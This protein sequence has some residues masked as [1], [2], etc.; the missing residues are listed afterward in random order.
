MRGKNGMGRGWLQQTQTASLLILFAGVTAPAAEGQTTRPSAMEAEPPQAQPSEAEGQAPKRTFSDFWTRPTLT[1]DW[2]GARKALEE[3]GWTFKIKYVQ[4]FQQNF[5]GGLQ[6]NNGHRFSGSYDLAVEADFDK[7]KLIP[8]GSFYIK[9]RGNYSEG[10]NPDKV[11]ALFTVNSDAFEDYPI[12]VR[13]WWYKQE[14]FDGKLEFRVG[15]IQTHKDLFDIS[16]YAHHEDEDFLNR[17]SIRDVI[18]PHTNAIGAF[19]KVEPVEGLYFQAAALDAQAESRTRTGFDTAFH[20]EDWFNGFWELG[21][22]PAW[23]TRRGPMPGRYRIGWWYDPIPKEVFEKLEEDEEPRTRTGDTGIYLGLDQMIF[24]ENADPDD[25]Q[26]LGLFSRLGLAHG[27]VNQV[28]LYW[29]AGLSYKGLI[30]TRDQDVFGFAVAQA[31]L[32]SQYRNEVN[33]KA[34][35][36]TVYEW[37][38]SYYLTPWCIISPDFQVVTNPGGETDDRDAIIG[39]IRIRLM[40]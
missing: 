23:K 12:F 20:D 27:E 13:K 5:R 8:G 6:T 31:V 37:Y 16:L 4:Q 26:G 18:V 24:K 33:P 35:R 28:N 25:S 14:L 3:A 22:A 38:Y 40:F 10:I 39:G 30:P 9:A 11:G 1:G 19:V 2:G 34:D 32:S 29:E 36:E 17:L 21:F 15:R 7:M